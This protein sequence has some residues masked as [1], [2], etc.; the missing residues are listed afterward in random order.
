MKYTQTQ[1]AHG[2]GKVVKEAEFGKQ[3]TGGMFF[4]L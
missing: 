1:L 2:L 3:K 4:E